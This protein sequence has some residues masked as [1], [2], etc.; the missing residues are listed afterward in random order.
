MAPRTFVYVSGSSPTLSIFALDPET[1]ALAPR[2]AADGG[3]NPTY[4]A[5]DPAR[6]F[7]YAGN[8]GDGRV[9]AFALDPAT[10]ALARLGDASTAAKGHAA[11]VTHLSVHPSGRWLLVDHFDSGHIAVLPIAADGRPGAPIDV[12]R[13]ADEAHQI[14]CDAAGRYVFVPCRAGNRVASYRFDV[15]TGQLSAV[16]PPV[17]PDA[18]GAGPRHLAFHPDGRHAYVINELD[19]TITSYRYDAATGLLSAP[20]VLST[21]PAGVVERAAAHVV[22]HPS[23]R[24]VYGS[25]RTHDSIAS[26]AVDARSGRLRALGHETGG[27]LVAQP[28]GFTVDPSGRWLLVA[29]QRADTLLVFRVDGDT[30]GLTLTGAPIA[31]PREPQFVG[32][33]TLPV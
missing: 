2:G 6:R 31:V 18:P 13:P 11:E 27:G 3:V 26:F 14:V 17:V 16:N 1:G 30:G 32:A 7:L 22:V 15:Q 4:L 21:V 23:G 5:W 29:N 33:L 8:G 12:E 10:G 24:F 20:E 25:N 28:R 9:T 19:A